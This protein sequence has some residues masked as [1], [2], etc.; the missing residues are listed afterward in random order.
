MVIVLVNCLRYLKYLEGSADSILSGL[1]ATESG[2][3]QELRLVLLKVWCDKGSLGVTDTRLHLPV[4]FPMCLPSHSALW[5]EGGCPFFFWSCQGSL[6][7]S[8]L[9]LPLKPV[10]L[11]IPLYVLWKAFEIK[12]FGFLAAKQ[13]TLLFRSLVICTFRVYWH[14]G[15]LPE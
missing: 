3:T 12:Q 4:G 1:Q 9:D 10:F 14:W 8:R 13:T 6:K 5:G 7:Q 11:G 2:S 15:L